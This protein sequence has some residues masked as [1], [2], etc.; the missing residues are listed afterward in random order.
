[1]ITG[2]MDPLVNVETIPIGPHSPVSPATSFTLVEW[3]FP[4]ATAARK[5][6]TRLCWQFVVS[7][8]IKT[9][10]CPSPTFP[11]F[12][13]TTAIYRHVAEHLNGNEELGPE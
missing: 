13:E 8:A 11:L 6:I 5:S 1:M 2:Y 9:L 12:I 7:H 3:F 10:F 4:P